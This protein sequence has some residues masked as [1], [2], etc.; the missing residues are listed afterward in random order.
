MT[1]KKKKKQGSLEKKYKKTKI[2]KQRT[3][4]IAKQATMSLMYG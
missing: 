1:K 4:I 3:I 2:T